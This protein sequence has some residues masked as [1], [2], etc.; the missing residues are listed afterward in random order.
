MPDL[1]THHLFGQQVLDTAALPSIAYKSIANYPGVFYWGAQGPDLM[2]YH[3]VLL[4]GSKL[5]QAART[6]HREQPGKL[7]EEFVRIILSA[8]QNCR[9]ILISYFCGFLCHYALDAVVHPYV[10]FWQKDFCQMN[11]DLS[12]SGAHSFIESS[13]DMALHQRLTGFSAHDFDLR[14]F[15]IPAP[16][17]N[18]IAWC[19]SRLLLNVYGLS[20]SPQ[21]I[22]ECF[23]DTMRLEKL[24]YGDHKLLA[25]AVALTE[26]FSG[27]RGAASGHFKLKS[28]P[29]DWDCLNLSHSSW[30]NPYD[31]S[32]CYESIPQMM[33]RAKEDLLHYY[34]L[35]LPMLIRGEAQNIPLSV[36]FRGEL[37]ESV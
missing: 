4:G 16:Q 15:S 14:Q 20:F 11:D 1:I 33:E 22:E 32:I 3:R 31:H 35:Y 13:I 2:F 19:Y 27:R 9:E 26:R 12:P 25:K 37:V 34:D 28:T 18:V 24:F 6:M 10:Y 23:A 7:M 5:N 8:P 36:N 17:K 29:P 30:Q 21:T